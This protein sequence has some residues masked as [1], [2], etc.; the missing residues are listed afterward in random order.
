[1]IRR[2]ALPWSGPLWLVL[3]A[4]LLAA[5]VMGVYFWRKHPGRR[6]ALAREPLGA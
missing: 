1:M 6:R 5:A 2:C 3:V 4:N